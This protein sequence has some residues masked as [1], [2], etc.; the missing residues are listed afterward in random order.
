[1]ASTSKKINGGYRSGIRSQPFTAVDRNA[2]PYYELILDTDMAPWLI[3]AQFPE[4]L[5]ESYAF[6]SPAGTVYPSPEIKTKF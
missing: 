5:Q 3:I 4:R 6:L 1:M 2:Q